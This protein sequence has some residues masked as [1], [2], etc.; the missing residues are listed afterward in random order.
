MIIGAPISATVTPGSLRTR[1]I[2]NYQIQ[3]QTLAKAGK[4]LVTLPPHLSSV[5]LPFDT[6]NLDNKI[7]VYVNST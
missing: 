3:A 6:S 1:N 2:T 5:M 7:D 4:L